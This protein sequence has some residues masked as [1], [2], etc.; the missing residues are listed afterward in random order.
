VQTAEGWT[1]ETC[2]DRA[3]PALRGSMSKLERSS[4]VFTWD[5]C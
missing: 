1:P 5:P 4:E 2:I 3:L